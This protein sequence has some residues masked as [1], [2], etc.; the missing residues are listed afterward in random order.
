MQND[1]YLIPNCPCYVWDGDAMIPVKEL[2]FF[3]GYGLRNEPLFKRQLNV[4]AALLVSF[5]HYRP[6]GTEW[7]FAPDWAV[8]STV[9]SDGMIEFWDQTS[10]EWFLT[11]DDDE[12]HKSGGWYDPYL[13]GGDS[14]MKCPDESRYIDG[15]WE[16]SLRKKR[17]WAERK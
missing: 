15:A 9:D 8:C 14:T 11:A 2:W 10:M 3:V 13:N 5:D 6:I 4:S 1:P 17:P 16:T 7:D 12:K